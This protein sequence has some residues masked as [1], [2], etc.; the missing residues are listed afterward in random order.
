MFASLVEAGAPRVLV[1]VG[2]THCASSVW[3][4]LEAPGQLSSICSGNKLFISSNTL[5]R[6]SISI[7][8]RLMS[9]SSSRFY[10]CSSPF[11]FVNSVH[12]WSQF[13]STCFVPQICEAMCDHPQS[14]QFAFPVSFQCAPPSTDACC[15]IIGALATDL[16][17]RAN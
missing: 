13:P 1:V 9:A 10:Q 8:H 7:W 17:G 15:R 3:W 12:Y 4:L 6:R 16:V 14:L 5:R 2:V 11:S